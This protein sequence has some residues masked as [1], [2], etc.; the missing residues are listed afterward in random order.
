MRVPSLLD[1]VTRTVAF[2]KDL[3]AT[4]GK[5]SREKRTTVPMLFTL[6]EAEKTAAFLL[7]TAEGAE[8]ELLKQIRESAAFVR[9]VQ[10]AQLEVA[11]ASAYEQAA[12]LCDSFAK[13][14]GR[15]S[16]CTSDDVGLLFEECAKKLRALK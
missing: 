13:T 15:P 11:R 6:E 14:Y 8:V 5:F 16:D 4:A 2:A 10:E 3:R 1:A 12:T 9:A 7:T